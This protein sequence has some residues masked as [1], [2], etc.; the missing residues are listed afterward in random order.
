MAVRHITLVKKIRADGTPCRKCAD[1]LD[2]LEKDGHL[3]SIDR[4][5][6]ADERDPRSEGWA[7]AARHQVTAA[8][9]F[10]VEE[11]GVERIHSVYFRFLREVL[12]R[13]PRERDELRELL[14]A[15]PELDFI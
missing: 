1:V 2:R 5:V 3:N 12:Q 6:V 14:D 13:R 11:D 4:V 15:N 8:P 10:I 9:F 7:L